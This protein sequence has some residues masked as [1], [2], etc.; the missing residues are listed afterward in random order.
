[1]DFE[2]EG[3]TTFTATIANQGTE[4]TLEL[5][6]DRAD[7]LLIGEIIVPPA[8]ESLHWMELTTNVT[9]A[10]GVQDLYIKLK[11]STDSPAILLREWKFNKQNEV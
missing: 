2:S 8:T 9:G 7:G 3:P 4:G 10:K 11:S 5:R 1:M 6:L